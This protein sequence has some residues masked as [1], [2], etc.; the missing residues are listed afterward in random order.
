MSGASRPLE[1]AA[2]LI[3]LGDAPCEVIHGAIVYKAEPSAEHGDAQ[4]GLG[5]AIRSRFHGPT[6]GPRGPGGWWILSEVDVELEKHEVYRP[7]L[8]GWR[9]DRVAERPRGRPVRVRPDWVCEVLSASNAQPD[10]VEKFEVYRRVAI[11][12]YWIIDPAT[13]TLTVHR[14]TAE[15]YL[16][17][18]RATRGS[19]VRAEPFEAIELAIGTL[20]GDD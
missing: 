3:A 12:H 10:L 11:P 18:L 5:S 17:A 7:D 19:T 20:C 4:L 9:R 13:E 14:W 16:I 15:G 2:S 1:T 6:G 8:V